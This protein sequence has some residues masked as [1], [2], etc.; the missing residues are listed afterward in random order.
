MFH[1]VQSSTS[2]SVATDSVE[3]RALVW[4][5]E[6]VARSAITSSTLKASASSLH[7]QLRQIAD[8]G[9]TSKS[10]IP[11][12]RAFQDVYYWAG[13]DDAILCSIPG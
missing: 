3:S 10:T 1:L 7:A 8:D 4:S 6:H 5:Q 11:R 9:D 13:E 2:N 12:V